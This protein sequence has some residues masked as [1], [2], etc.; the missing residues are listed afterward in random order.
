MRED[1]PVPWFVIRSQVSGY[2]DP[3]ES[4]TTPGGKY[5]KD[6]AGRAAESAAT[7][8]AGVRSS[9]ARRRFARDKEVL[10]SLGISIE[11][12]PR[13]SLDTGGYYIRRESFSHPAIHLTAEHRRLLACLHTTAA[14]ES[15]SPVLGPLLSAL[16][17]LRFDDTPYDV[18]RTDDRLPVFKLGADEQPSVRANLAA[19]INAARACKIVTFYYHSMHRDDVGRRAVEPYGTFLREGKWYLVGRCTVKQAIRLFRLDRIMTQVQVNRGNPGR[20]DFKRPRGF[21]LKKYLGVLPWEKGPKPE[22]KKLYDAKITFDDEVWWMARESLAASTCRVSAKTGGVV[23][24]MPVYREEP[25]IRWLLKFGPHAVVTS[26]KRLRNL[27]IDTVKKIRQR[28]T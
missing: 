12:V 16:Q 1:E 9:A 3:D 8:T 18:P 20:A 4:E 14:L 10:K 2:N 13:N 28:H 21:R 15:N 7:Y 23:V 27:L 19:L 5:S 25:L 24:S 22:T 6:G 11:Y 17:K 26:P